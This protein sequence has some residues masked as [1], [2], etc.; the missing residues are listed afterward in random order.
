[1]AIDCGMK[2]KLL[3]VLCSA[4]LLSSLAAL[5]SARSARAAA[6]D[7]ARAPSLTLV[8]EDAET[9]V[10]SFQDAGHLCFI[11]STRGGSGI[12]LQ[13]PH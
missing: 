11:A 9:R 1:M 13:C 5:L 10:Y 7:P 12:S 2:D 8:A 4:A 3:A 6:S